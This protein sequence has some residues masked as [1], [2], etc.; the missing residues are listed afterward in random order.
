M[1]A[2][3]IRV[4]IFG[5]LA[6]IFA[7]P[8]YTE[9]G[10]DWTLHSVSELAGQD[11]RNAW[12]MRGGLFA[13]GLASIVG[14]AA[15]RPRFNLLFAAFGLFIAM[16]ALFPHKP[17][18]AGRPFSEALDQVHSVF[19]S[20]GG[21]CAVLGFVLKARVAGTRPCALAYAVIAIAY[22]LL[23]LLMFSVP[24]LQ[25]LFQRLLFVSYAAWVLVDGLPRRRVDRQ[26][27]G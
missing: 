8:W 11:T 24:S 2:L 23:P 26:A 7:G 6:A 14:Y 25:G 5:C 15:Y 20:L 27:S 19:A 18:V 1:A 4:L 16:S 10:Y 13:L 3:S 12:I 22:T 21:L 17:F 9:P